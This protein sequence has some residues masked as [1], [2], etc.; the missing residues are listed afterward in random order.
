L[1]FAKDGRGNKRRIYLLQ[2]A[3]VQSKMCSAHAQLARQ[4][5]L[6]LGS[7]FQPL[8]VQDRAN[9]EKN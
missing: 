4:Y 8:H 3:T 2:I 9:P 1:R 7:G 5:G 6:E